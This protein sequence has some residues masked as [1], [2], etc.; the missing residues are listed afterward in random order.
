MYGKRISFDRWRGI[1]CSRPGPRRRR[2]GKTLMDYV[3]C[4]MKHILH[5]EFILKRIVQALSPYF[6]GFFHSVFFS[7]IHIHFFLSFMNVF[8]LSYLFLF[9]FS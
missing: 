5:Y 6:W 4:R 3:M 8:Y 1:R 7:F 2:E 9:F